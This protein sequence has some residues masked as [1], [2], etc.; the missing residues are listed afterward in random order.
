MYQ[1]NNCLIKFIE[2]KQLAN[3]EQAAVNEK[4]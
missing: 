1:S 3:C 4:G 2:F